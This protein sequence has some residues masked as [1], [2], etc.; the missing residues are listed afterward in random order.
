M[1]KKI[2][3]WII[4]LLA[5]SL[6]L[7]SCNDVGKKK[8]SG[9]KEKSSSEEYNK[10]DGRSQSKLKLTFKIDTAVVTHQAVIKTDLGIIKISLYGQDAPKT[11]DNFTG[12][13]KKGYY[14]GVLFHRIA[15]NFLVQTGD[16]NTKSK[17]KKQEWGM[18]GK[19][20]YGKEFNDELNNLAPSYKNGY[21][22]GT[23]AMANRGPN[24]NTSQFFICLEDAGSLKHQWTIFG[25]VTEGMDVVEKI[26]NME[27]IPGPY[28]PDDGIPVKPI[29][30]ISVSINKIKN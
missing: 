6:T 28:D 4:I 23:V 18:G 24:T 16:A 12:L 2:I 29:R 10:N 15:K 25:K 5:I 30:I 27:I 7:Y 11:V 19:S 8:P 9:K 17:S 3:S 22:P 13:A 14:N 1:N 21:T 20:I 26:S